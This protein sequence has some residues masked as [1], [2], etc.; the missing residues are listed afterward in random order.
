GQEASDE[1]SRRLDRTLYAHPAMFVVEHAL[2]RLLMDWGVKP[3]AMIGY[4]LGEYTAACIAGVLHLEE[5]LWLVAERARLIEELPA[6]SM[7][8]IPLPESE[9]LSR[10]GAE[11]SLAAVN[12]PQMCVVAGSLAAVAALEGELAESGVVSR[13]LR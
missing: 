5:A 13:R 4:S 3:K 8:A 1:A 11:L 2:A 12:A 10:L 9:M 7:L 6:G